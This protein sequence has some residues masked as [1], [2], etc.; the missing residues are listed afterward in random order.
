MELD[1]LAGAHTMIRRGQP[2]VAVA[3]YHQPNDLAAL[4]KQL[5]ADLPRHRWFLR[6][7]ERDGWELIL[8][9]LPGERCAKNPDRITVGAEAA[10]TCSSARNISIRIRE[11]SS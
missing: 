8:Y 3:A 9:G 10:P 1:V 4:W 2:V 6:Q 5:H 7:H 11:R